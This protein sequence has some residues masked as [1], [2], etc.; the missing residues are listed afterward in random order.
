M[1]PPLPAK[2]WIC[3]VFRES[4]AGPSLAPMLDN[5][6]DPPAHRQ[7]P[8]SR[9]QARV[10]DRVGHGREDPRPLPY[11]GPERQRGPAQAARRLS[12]GD[13]LRP[14]A[15]ATGRAV[16]AGRRGGVACGSRQHGGH[17]S[18]ENRPA[19]EHTPADARAPPTRPAGAPPPPA[20]PGAP[21]RAQ[22]GPPGPPPAPFF[23]P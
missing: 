1:S 12:A 15:P 18:A 2:P 23:F 4:G 13:S 14:A 10:V 6:G 21:P 17:V 5:H 3:P 22:R 16:D 9:S 7:P 19:G 20:A 11:R 8:P